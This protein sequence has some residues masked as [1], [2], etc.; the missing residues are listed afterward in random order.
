MS[1]SWVWYSAISAGESVRL[2]AYSTTSLSF[3][4]HSSRPIAGFS[5]K[6]ARVAVEGFEV[7]PQLAQV[8]GLETAHLQLDGDQAIEAPV[9]EQQVE[10]EVP[11]AN[12]HRLLGT[13]ETKVAAKFDQ[14]RLEPREQPAMQVRLAVF[15]GQIEEFD[16]VGVLEDAGGGAVIL[17]HRR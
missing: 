15:I 5:C 4:A 2:R 13:D 10:C 17:S 14:K 6:L 11:A 3:E 12:Q 1:G 8:L 7:E 16:H 9:K